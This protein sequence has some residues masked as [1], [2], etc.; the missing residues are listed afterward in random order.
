MSL[1]DKGRFKNLD[2]LILDIGA[3]D[4]ISKTIIFID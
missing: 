4:K 3:I 2:F 1:I